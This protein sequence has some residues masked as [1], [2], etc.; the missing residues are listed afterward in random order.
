MGS[1]KRIDLPLYVI[2]ERP[3]D[4]PQ[5][6]VLRKQWPMTDGNAV[7]DPECIIAASLEEARAALPP[8]LTNIGR[9]EDD[10]PAIKEVWI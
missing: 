4:H 2:Y 7:P 9:Y 3:L 5:N 6:W 1:V 10:D 8:G